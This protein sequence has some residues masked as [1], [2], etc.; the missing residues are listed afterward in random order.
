MQRNQFHT[1]VYSDLGGAQQ[2]WPNH[3][4]AAQSTAAEPATEPATV[5]SAAS[6]A[7]ITTIAAA[8]KPSGASAESTC[9]TSVAATAVSASQHVLLCIHADQRHQSPDNE[10]RIDR[11]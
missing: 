10:W 3:R 9:P 6:T 1:R 11:V 4:A 5:A 7:S 2:L 8:T